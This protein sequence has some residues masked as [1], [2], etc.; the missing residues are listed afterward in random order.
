MFNLEESAKAKK[1]FAENKKKWCHQTIASVRA[2]QMKETITNFS[3]SYYIAMRSFVCASHQ[4]TNRLYR[5]I[6]GSFTRLL[7]RGYQPAFLHLIS[8]FLQ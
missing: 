2:W 7:A 1:S 6:V 5:P 3:F 4:A 8:R